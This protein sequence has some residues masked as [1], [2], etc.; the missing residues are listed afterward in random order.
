MKYW[1]LTTEFTQ[2]ISEG[3]GAYVNNHAQIFAEKGH[4]VLIIKGGAGNVDQVTTVSKNIT[5]HNFSLNGRKSNHILGYNG[6]LSYEF[7]NE[8]IKLLASQTPDVIE[9][10]E[11]MGIGYYLL[12]QKHIGEPLLK[13]IPVI[14]T[15]HMPSFLLHE[16]NHTPGYLFPEYWNGEMEKFSILAADMFLSPGRHLVTLLRQ[17]MEAFPSLVNYVPYP[18]QTVSKTTPVVQTNE[19]TFVVAGHLSYAKGTMKLL[20][21]A[22]G[23]W[24]KGMDFHLHFIGNSTNIVTT[25]QLTISELIRKKYAAHIEAGRLQLT[26]TLP[27]DR[28]MAHMAAAKAVI[29][30][31]LVDNLPQEALYAMA[32]G[33]VVLSSSE[34]GLDELLQDNQSGF[35]FNWKQPNSFEEKLNRILSL[36]A[37][38]LKSMGENAKAAAAVCSSDNYY[39]VKHQFITDFIQSTPIR[40][41]FP[42]LRP[43][44]KQENTE[45][46]ALLDGLTVVLP[47]YNMGE[48][49][50]ETVQSI[51]ASSYKN[52][53]IIIVNDGSTDEASVLKLNDLQQKYPAVEIIHQNNAGLSEARNTGLYLTKTRY[54]AFL[55]PD[56]TIHPEYYQKSTAILEKY[57]NIGFVSCWLRYFEA[58]DGTWPAQNP[59][60][61]YL[62]Y[63][64][65]VHS[66]TVFKTKDIL[67]TG[68]YDK[69]F[70]Y[71]MEDYEM[72]VHMV[73]KGFHGVSIPETLYNYRI[74]HQSMARGF[75]LDKKLFLY[76]LLSKKHKALF[77]KYGAEST[78]ILNA[79]GPGYLHANPTFASN[80]SI[81]ASAPPDVTTEIAKKVLNNYPALRKMARGL[82]R[83]LKPGN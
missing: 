68:G 30:P 6:A 63:H 21:A 67:Q 74:R 13:N 65:A 41:N 51:L 4:E 80:F 15:A 44:P 49:V 29:V 31:S 73:S 24:K 72:A 9:V 83:L 28:L 46:P 59:E 32:A 23:L 3:I 5:L 27:L 43:Q 42:V 34:A 48:F 75:T 33:K 11:Y 18:L 37:T 82:K 14:V 62:L 57:D 40:K 20:A 35:I 10:Q 64:N 36:T 2:E 45:T 79:N 19:H 76:T 71:G 69:E 12:L 25:E 56:D 26:E 17:H 81:K 77:N 38:E 60:V 16:Y 78:N 70:V 7:A 47:Y 39:T 52:I 66:G 53:K 22:A 50:E 61:P 8:V 58:S 55:D 54:V 1:I